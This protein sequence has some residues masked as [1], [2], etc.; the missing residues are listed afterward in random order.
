MRYL[1][2]SSSK[3]IAKTTT[4]VAAWSPT[5][6]T[7]SANTVK[8]TAQPM[9]RQHVIPSISLTASNYNNN[10]NNS[11]NSS[12]DQ[13]YS[14]RTK[15]WGQQCGVTC[16]CVVRFDIALDDN[17]RVIMA[18]YTA[19]KILTTTIP[20]PIIPNIND[21][22][23]SNSSMCRKQQ[24]Q[25]PQQQQHMRPVWTNRTKRLQYVSCPCPTLHTL[26]LQSIE[27]FI[28][29]PIYQLIN[30]HEFQSA[31]SSLAFRDTIL[32]SLRH[33]TTTTTTTTTTKSQSLRHPDRNKKSHY[34]CFDLVEDAITALLKGYIPPPR[35]QPT[36]EFRMLLESD[37]DDD[38]ITENVGNSSNFSLIND[39]DDYDDD[40]QQQ[41]L[42]SSMNTENVTSRN[43]AFTNAG[44]RTAASTSWQERMLHPWWPFTSWTNYSNHKNNAEDDSD[45]NDKKTI[46]NP[47]VDQVHKTYALDD[48]KR[49]QQRL[50]TL[51]YGD[52][53]RRHWTA[54]DWLDWLEHDRE[55][56]Q[57]QHQLRWLSLSSVP[58]VAAN[59]NKNSYEENRVMDWL[60]Y[61]DTVLYND[62]SNYIHCTRDRQSA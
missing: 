7:A 53:D 46:I 13:L 29:R 58:P 60:T 9:G 14:V 59:N 41:L 6:V 52:S 38:T 45:S 4:S 35:Q 17:D 57:Q 37:V 40:D 30:L 39:D 22:Q 18:E 26:C 21:M 55:M 10:N 50:S 33:D 16:G 3:Q 25:Q 20:I 42:H 62:R 5:H 27:Y 49:V 15:K 44:D 43:D 48:V 28:N 32:S 56:K 11:D 23:R 36:E 8:I 1:L 34:H 2:N 31:R 24:S 12:N 61:V 54:L 51:S 47:G 19:K